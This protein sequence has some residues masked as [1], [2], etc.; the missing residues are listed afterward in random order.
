[1]ARLRVVQEGVA[2]QR[3]RL[4]LSIVVSVKGAAVWSD[5]F[6]SHIFVSNFG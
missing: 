3:A 2:F 5:S 4:S 1:M 6:L